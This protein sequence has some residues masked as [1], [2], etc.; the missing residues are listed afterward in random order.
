MPGVGDRTA[1]GE[2]ATG[3]AWAA[4]S[5]VS[6]LS[7]A[8]NRALDAK[9]PLAKQIKTEKKQLVSCCED[10]KGI[11]GASRSRRGSDKASLQRPRT[12]TGLRRPSRP[13]SESKRTNLRDLHYA[14]CWEPVDTQEAYYMLIISHYIIVGFLKSFI[15]VHRLSVLQVASVQGKHYFK[16]IPIGTLDSYA[17]ESILG[18]KM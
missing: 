17:F 7:R 4:A 10:G 18:S 9:N 6:I 16:N 5:Q 3:S 8:P 12:A 15:I 2:E 11:T 1:R 13:A 14:P